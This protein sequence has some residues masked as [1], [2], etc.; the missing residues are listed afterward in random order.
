MSGPH[1]WANIGAAVAEARRALAAARITGISTPGDEAAPD[2]W[3]VVDVSRAEDFAV[4]LLGVVHQARPGTSPI[5]LMTLRTWLENHGS[6]DGTASALG[7]HRN[8]VRNRIALVQQL[9]GRD[10]ND[11]DVR[12]QLW[13]ALRWRNQAQL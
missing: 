11:A 10:L 1:P 2:L 7:V 13:F 4:S 3:D 9:I 6:W 12:M 5:L 8:T